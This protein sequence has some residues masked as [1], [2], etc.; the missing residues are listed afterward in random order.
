M[1]LAFVLDSWKGGCSKL[2]I[3]QVIGVCLLSTVGPGT[4][5]Y[6][7]EVTHDGSLDSFRRGGAMLERPTM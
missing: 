2:R 4:W 1:Y 7:N 6:A 3:A 5:I